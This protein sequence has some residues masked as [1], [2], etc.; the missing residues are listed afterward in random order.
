[1]AREITPE[2]L[3]QLKAFQAGLN[4]EISTRKALRGADFGR[5]D[6]LI[7]AARLLL[8]GRQE[9]LSDEQTVEFARQL[10]P[11]MTVE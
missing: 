6:E 10:L 8:A 11:K 5:N 2:Q 3:A 9:G 7:N 1:M 4:P